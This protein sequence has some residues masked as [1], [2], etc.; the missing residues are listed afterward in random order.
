MEKKPKPKPN[1]KTPKTTQPR[2]WDAK[3]AKGFTY[4]KVYRCKKVGFMSL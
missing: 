4:Q 2:S 1:Q 3:A